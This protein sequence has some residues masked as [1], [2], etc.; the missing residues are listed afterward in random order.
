MYCPLKFLIYNA[1][2]SVV[3]TRRFSMIIFPA[4]MNAFCLAPPK[5]V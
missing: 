1:F 2:L 5:T 3:S 4:T